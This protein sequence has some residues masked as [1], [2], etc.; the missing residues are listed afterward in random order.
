MAVM[1]SFSILGHPGSGR[2]DQGRLCRGQWDDGPIRTIFVR[3]CCGRCPV[4]A[5]GADRPPREPQNRTLTFEGLSRRTRPHQNLDRSRTRHTSR[6]SRTVCRRGRLLP[7]QH[8]ACIFNFLV[9]QTADEAIVECIAAEIAPKIATAAEDLAVPVNLGIVPELMTD[10]SQVFLAVNLL[11]FGP[12]CCAA[13]RA[14]A[15]K[16]FV[17]YREKSD[18]SSA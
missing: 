11:V 9:I 7:D 1:A 15:H 6:R 16:V 5:C 3:E 17:P 4:T 8:I 12:A 14:Q 18:P 13:S 10:L 2:P